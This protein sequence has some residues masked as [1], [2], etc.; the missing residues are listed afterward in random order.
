MRRFLAHWRTVAVV[1]VVAAILAVALWPEAIE[2]DTARVVRAPLQVTIDEEGETRVHDRFVVSAPVAGRLQRIDLK[3]GDPVRRGKTVVARLTPAPPTLLD[4]RARTE[5]TAAVD[6]A[7]ATLGQAQAER[8]RTEATLERARSTLQR[9][10]RLAEAGAISTDDLESARTEVRAAEQVHKAAQFAVTVAQAQLDAARARLQR[11]DGASRAVDV[12]SPID[13][14]ILR[15]FRESEA[16]VPA[17][18]PLVEIGDP[19]AIEVVADLLSTDAVRVS[20][21][22]PV[23]IEQWGGGHAL[24]GRVER[25]EPS[26]FMKVSALGVEEQRVNVIVDFADPA[27][28]SRVLGDGYRVEVRIVEAEVD[29]ALT[30]PIGSLFRRGD[31]WA[32]FVVDGDGRVRVLEVTLGRRNSAIAEVTGGLREGQ[33]VVLHPPDTLVDGTRVIERDS[34]RP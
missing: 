15:R 11:P 29:N 14:V 21:G 28:A 8:A 17:G 7:R 22:D 2:V 18:E 12:V 30:V 31:A 16:V 25:V 34:A 4:A 5:L 13:G 24:A 20:A 9:Q 27:T 1:L 23:L 6:S 19:T 10:E 33:R 3:P 26:G 32:V